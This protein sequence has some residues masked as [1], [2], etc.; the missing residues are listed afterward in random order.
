MTYTF[1]KDFL[2]G[3]MSHIVAYG[4]D[5][6]SLTLID[7]TYTIELSDNVPSEEYP[8]L[9]HEYNFQEIV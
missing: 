4:L 2:P 9:Q 7:N 8:H 5:V 1:D 6:V 3:V